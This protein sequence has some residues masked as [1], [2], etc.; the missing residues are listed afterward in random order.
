MMDRPIALYVMKNDNFTLKHIFHTAP[1]Y[2]DWRTERADCVLMH[3]RQ[4]GRVA[5]I[6]G[7]CGSD[8]AT[9][10][11]LTAYYANGA[12]DSVNFVIHPKFYDDRNRAQILIAN[13]GVN[14]YPLTCEDGQPIAY[15]NSITN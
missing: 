9:K 10:V 6:D 14:E 13:E 1:E 15:E 12:K 4:N 2:V 5:E 3:H 11:T 8:F 7:Y